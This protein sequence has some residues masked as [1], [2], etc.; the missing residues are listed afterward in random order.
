MDLEQVMLEAD[1]FQK[2]NNRA[3]ISRNSSDIQE[4][5]GEYEY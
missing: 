2:R 4:E 1:E 5:R 3:F